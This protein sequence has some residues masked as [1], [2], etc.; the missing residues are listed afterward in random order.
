MLPDVPD[1]SVLD[2][3]ANSIRNQLNVI[4]SITEVSN[5]LDSNEPKIIIKVPATKYQQ[6]HFSEK[7]T[8]CYQSLMTGKK[9][10]FIPLAERENLGISESDKKNGGIFPEIL[11]IPD[12]IS[13]VSSHYW[14]LRRRIFIKRNE[15]LDE[16]HKELADL[17]GEWW[18]IYTDYMNSEDW[19]EK[20]EQRKA[21]DGFKCVLCDSEDKLQV[22]HYHYDNAGD[23]RMDDLITVCYDCHRKIHYYKTF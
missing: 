5:L 10:K 23:E 11:N 14:D 1:T 2:N 4:Y 15:L 17:K 20:R 22:H 9:S 19:K 13:L 8:F 7:F 21:I 6:D 18:E 12:T 16:Y 3:Y